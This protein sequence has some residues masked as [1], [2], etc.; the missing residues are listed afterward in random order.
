MSR[1]T[2]S[3][4]LT[5]EVMTV[6]LR[7]AR[8]TSMRGSTTRDSGGRPCAG[9]RFPGAPRFAQ[10]R[11]CWARCRFQSGFAHGPRAGDRRRGATRRRR[12]SGAPRRA[13][14]AIARPGA[15]R[16][17]AGRGRQRKPPARV[18]LRRDRRRRVED[19]RRRHDAGSRSPTSSSRPRRSARSPSRES[20]P[21]VV[22]VGMGET[23]LRGNIIQGDGVYKTTDAGKTW[24]HV[25]LE[26]T[27]A[28]ARIR[29]HP[30]NPDIVYVAALGNPYGAESRA[31]RLQVERRRQDVGRGA[32]PRRQDRRG[33]SRRSIRRTRTCSTPRSGRSTAR[34]TR[35]RAAA[36]AADSSRRPT[37]AQTGPSSR[38][39]RACRPRC[40]ARSASRCPAP[41]ATAS[42]R[43]IEADDGGVFL[44]DDAGATWKL[45]ND[46]RRLRQ[47]AFYYTRIYADPQG[48]G[49]G[50]RPQHRHLSIDRRRQD[51]SQPIR[52][53]HGDNHDL[54][55]APN[56]PQA[57]DQQQRRRRQRVGQRR[58]DAGP[59][60]TIRPRSSTTSSRP[61]TC[62]ITSAARSRTTRTACVLEQP[63]TAATL[64]DGRRRRERLHRARSERRRR[65][66]RRQL[67]R[68][69]DADQPPHRRAARDQR[70]ARQPDGLLVGRHHRALPV[71]LSR[72]SSRRPIRRRSTSRSQHVWKSTNEGQSWKRISPDLT[73][74]D[75]STLGP[76]GGPITMDQTG[77]ETYATVFTLAPSPLD[78]NVIWA[79]SD[80]G[81]VHVT[82]DGGKNWTNVTP[83]DLPEF[84]RI[85]LIEASP[86][87]AGHGLRRRESLPA[88]R[89]RAVRLQDDRLRQDL[90]EDRQ[91]HAGRRLRARDPRGP[92]ANAGCCSSAP[93]PASTSRSTMA[94]TGSRCG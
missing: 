66:L 7:N 23:E 58:R 27:Q 89:P 85:S 84:T 19:D 26:K 44:S 24:T 72:S 33:R 42:T 69:A 80:D 71:D 50:L 9:R 2:L 34:R 83:P 82:R 91:R 54:W 64:Y 10:S 5:V 15:R 73:R 55:I 45:V 3:V 39:T 59:T 31:R 21:D 92:E 57:D 86:H 40:G 36:P 87:D 62:R 53:P 75:P 74:H 79:G 76:S 43:S 38:R 70:L 20:N 93:R 47:R 52:V 14:L 13:A 16:P 12:R 28:I 67:R 90:D 88:G 65:L 17:L 25:G 8:S 41:T 46:D 61:R 18:L 56:D 48:Q 11:C 6:L 22:Y 77:V 63:A 35:C 30:T 94:R 60:R 32:V 81:L 29:V 49:H 78:G 37:A 1:A 68:L 4:A 51:R